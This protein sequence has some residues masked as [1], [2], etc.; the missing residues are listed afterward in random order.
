MWFHINRLRSIR[1]P[2]FTA[3][4]RYLHRITRR[5]LFPTGS[6][7]GSGSSI[8]S[9]LSVVELQ[10]GSPDCVWR[11]QSLHLDKSSAG[12]GAA[13]SSPSSADVV[14]R[15]RWRQ[16]RWS[17]FWR[18]WLVKSITTVSDSKLL[19]LGPEATSSNRCLQKFRWMLVRVCALPLMVTTDR[20]T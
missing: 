9:S 18:C 7:P 8:G 2:S 19:L 17:Q 12:P 20:D 10:S 13:K 6:N 14:S 16:F 11:G 5:Q 3:S 1:A 15:S 4:K